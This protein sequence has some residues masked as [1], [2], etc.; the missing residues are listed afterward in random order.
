MKKKH[1]LYLL[2]QKSTLGNKVTFSLFCLLAL[3]FFFLKGVKIID[4][5][6]RD[7]Y[8]IPLLDCLIGLTDRKAICLEGRLIDSLAADL[9]Q[10]GEV[11]LA[12]VLWKRGN[13]GKLMPFW[14]KENDDDYSSHLFL[15]Q[16][17]DGG[18]NP[19]WHSSKLE[20]PICSLKVEDFNR[21]NRLELVVLE[22]EYAD[23][24]FS[25]QESQET[26]WHWNGWG[27]TRIE[28]NEY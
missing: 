16:L 15:Y 25:C 24:G 27:F 13:Y 3:L 19:L 28:G 11:E 17:K 7:Y 2:G 1:R 21:D 18:I 14:I 20:R 5:R 8:L 10:D 23:S 22:G 4:W 26:H 12:L 6:G 9:N